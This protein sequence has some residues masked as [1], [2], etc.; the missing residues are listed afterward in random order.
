MPDGRDRRSG[1]Q[2]ADDLPAPVSI[3][4]ATAAPPVRGGYW[5]RDG[6]RTT[7]ADAGRAPLAGLALAASARRLGAGLPVPRPDPRRV[8]RDPR[9]SPLL[10]AAVVARDWDRHSTYEERELARA[11]RRA[12]EVGAHQGR[13][14]PRPGPLGGPPGPAGEEG[15]RGKSVRH[16]PRP[17]LRSSA[18]GTPCA[19]AP[20]ELTSRG[21]ALPPAVRARGPPGAAPP[22]RRCRVRR[23]AGTAVDLFRRY[24]M[25]RPVPRRPAAAARATLPDADASAFDRLAGAVLASSTAH[26][27]A[28]L[29]R[30]QLPGT[31]RRPLAAP[32]RA[33]R[34]PPG[35]PRCTAAHWLSLYACWSVGP[36]GSRARRRG[37]RPAHRR[38]ALDPRSRAGAPG[39]P[40]LGPVAGRQSPTASS[41]ASS[42]ARSGKANASASAWRGGHAPPARP[43]PARGRPGLPSTWSTSAVRP[44][45]DRSGRPPSAPRAR[46]P[47]R[48]VPSGP[49]RAAA[50][51]APG[52][53]AH[54]HPAS[55]PAGHRCPAPA[56]W[57]AA[58]RA[59]R[60][61]RRAR[62][63]R[64]RPAHRPVAVGTAHRGRR[65]RRPPGPAATRTRS[66]GS[67]S[68]PSR[69]AASRA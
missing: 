67:T 33:C 31:S 11:R 17:F 3:R 65:R 10:V 37:R 7:D 52:R 12:G 51:A 49:R 56:R 34:R 26:R 40:A 39:H 15:R 9:W 18:C 28:P 48:R 21:A 58:G 66:G 30:A 44:P 69:T 2:G 29:L 16:P 23:P 53:S 46:P 47:R 1:W 22:C 27:W 24:P 60:P 41:A 32:G 6:G 43:A 42:P 62:R 14:R 68:I 50:S 55:A 63:R 64:A 20:S 36:P 5:P 19:R 57:P 59:G 13:P 8:R 61:P 45:G 25:S 4:E 54:A 35:R 38:P